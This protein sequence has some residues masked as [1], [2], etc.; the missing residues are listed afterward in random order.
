MKTNLAPLTALLSGLLFGWGLWLSGMVIP[1]RVLDFLDVAGSFNPALALVMAGAIGVYAPL[2]WLLMRRQ[3]PL[4]APR[5]ELPTL[6][7]IDR[8]LVGG[9]ALFGLGWGLSGVCPGPALVV[10]GSGLRAP[11][12]F[13][14]AMLL[15]MGLFELLAVP[16]ARQ[17]PVT[18][19]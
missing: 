6:R 15:G 13:V 11:L 1:G 16:Q 9:S 10:A 8:R 5:F 17:V 18:V 7:N 14:G 12:L 4:L 3:G 19:A 2:Y